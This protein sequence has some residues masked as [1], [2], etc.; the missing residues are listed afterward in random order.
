MSGQISGILSG[1]MAQEMKLEVLSNNMANANTVGFKEDRVFR[2]PSSASSVWDNIPGSSQKDL[3]I[4]NVSSLP[5]GS[6]TNFEQGHLKTTGNALDVALDGDGFFSVQT[7]KGLQYTRKGNFVLNSNGTL[8]TQ[9]GYPVL[10]NGGGE[11]RISGK[12]VVVASNGAIIVDGLE[13]DS[14]KIVDFVNKKGLLKIGDSL[15]RP[16]DPN[17]TGTP[18]VKTQVQQGAIE[19]SNVDSIKMM[20]EMIDVI[21]GYESYQKIL[22]SMNDTNGKTNEI[23]KLS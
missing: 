6:F 9:E 15:Y 4:N 1:T 18:A 16:Q 8:V 3:S 17:D 14:L 2:I 5:V 13:T 11:I 23:G 10:G 12:N 7:S 19:A 20:T 22:Q 21:R